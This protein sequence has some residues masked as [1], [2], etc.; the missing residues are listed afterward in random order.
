MAMWWVEQAERDAERV[1]NQRYRDKFAR[2]IVDRQLKQYCSVL[3][4][5]SA[6]CAETILIRAVQM[7]DLSVNDV[8]AHV[9]HQSA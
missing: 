2:R 5:E 1:R 9:R 8:S 7:H 6:S 4:D 3:A